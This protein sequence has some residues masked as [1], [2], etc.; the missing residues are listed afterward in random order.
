M[1]ASTSRPRP[2]HCKVH[3]G[4]CGGLG[5]GQ[6]GGEGGAVLLEVPGD[7]EKVMMSGSH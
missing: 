2:S 5:H 6:S 7:A 4:P 1:A 3:A